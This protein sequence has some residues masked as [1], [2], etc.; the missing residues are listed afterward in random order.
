MMSSISSS[1]K[2]PEIAN[3]AKDIW[4]Y[5]DVVSQHILTAI[6]F[7]SKEMKSSFIN[8][9]LILLLLLFCGL[10]GLVVSPFSWKSRYMALMHLSYQCRDEY[11]YADPHIFKLENSQFLTMPP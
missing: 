5:F 11:V 2:L 7:N 3:K 9:V 8:T 6:G 4:V 1:I 10:F